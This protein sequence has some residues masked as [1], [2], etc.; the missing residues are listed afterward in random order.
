MYAEYTRPQLTFLALHSCLKL[1]FIEGILVSNLP[2]LQ[3]IFMHLQAKMSGHKWIFRLITQ[4][5]KLVKD[6]QNSL[7]GVKVSHRGVKVS[8]RK[9]LKI[10]MKGV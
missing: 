5:L 6:V 2:H 7:K 10:T 9:G 1:F 4:G 8:H 3:A